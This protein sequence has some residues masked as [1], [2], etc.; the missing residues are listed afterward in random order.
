MLS[1]AAPA[2]WTV[3]A[4]VVLARGTVRQARSKVSTVTVSAQQNA[5][6]MPELRAIHA[7]SG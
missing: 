4:P 3:S 5:V 6:G 7:D 2:Q 1:N